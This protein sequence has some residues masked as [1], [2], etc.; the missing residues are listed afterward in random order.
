MM[1]I[2]GVPLPPGMTLSDFFA[3]AKQGLVDANIGNLVSPYLNDPNNLDTRLDVFTNM[4]NYSPENIN[5]NNGSFDA[6]NAINYATHGAEM[7][8]ENSYTDEQVVQQLGLEA[9]PIQADAI[10]AYN[11]YGLPLWFAKLKGLVG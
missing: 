3:K 9:L 7:A 11:R 5:L 10:T 8:D 1:K 2:N 6:V 4:L